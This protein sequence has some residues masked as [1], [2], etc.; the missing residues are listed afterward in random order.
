MPVKLLVIRFSSIGDIVLTSPVVRCLAEQVK[1]IT[2]HF[3]TKKKF[4]VIVESNPHIDKVWAFEKSL[5]EVI[6]NLVDEK[7]THIIDLH[8]NIRSN[9]VLLS[10]RKPFTS[11]NKLNIEKWLLVQLKVNLLPHKHIVERYLEA[12]YQLGIINDGKG[13]D[14]FIPEEENLDIKSDL[15]LLADGY[16]A[17]VIG[18]NHNTKILPADMVANLSKLI[19]LPIVLL[20]GKED[21]ERGN[22]ISKLSGEKALNLCGKFNIMQSASLVKQSVA[23]I[24]N[25][26]G[27]MHIAAAFEK[28]IVSIWGNTVPEFGMYPYLINSTPSLKA[29]V[30]NLKCR[31]C[32]KIGFKECPLKHFNCM[33]KQNIIEIASFINRIIANRV[34]DQTT[35]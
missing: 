24:S 13:L 1:D 5:S 15:P 9:R 11:F 12:A 28:P 18:G 33:R 29:E 35:Q 7:Y 23:V 4:A 27:L 3:L 10:L 14:F 32:S 20:G 19:N 26:T 22:L 21:L 6:P 16:I 25:D 30:K 17:I 31:P 34:L 8:K 2:I